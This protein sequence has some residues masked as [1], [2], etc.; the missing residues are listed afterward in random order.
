MADALSRP[1]YQA[2]PVLP[3]SGWHAAWPRILATVLSNP[4]AWTLMGVSLIGL[5]HLT[6]PWVQWPVAFAIPTVLAAWKRGLAWALPFAILGP[7]VRVLMFWHNSHGFGLS[8]LIINAALR[9]LVLVLVAIL[10]RHVVTLRARVRRLESL[11]PICA[12]CRRVRTEDNTWIGMD[13]YL[14]GAL[15][16]S[17]THGICPEC[18]AR[19]LEEEGP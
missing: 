7:F 5:D 10:V 19:L 8:T 16:T 13:T 18:S 14:A 11:L 6:T 3:K 15:G 1:G 12:W 2:P 17:P 4:L 9:A